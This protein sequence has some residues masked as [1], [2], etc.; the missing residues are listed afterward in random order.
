MLCIP[1]WGETVFT[2]LVAQGAQTDAQH[3]RGIESGSRP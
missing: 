3:F 1:P 2:N